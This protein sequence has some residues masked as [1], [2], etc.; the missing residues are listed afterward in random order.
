MNSSSLSRI[1]VFEDELP[2]ALHNSSTLRIRLA[3]FRRNQATTGELLRRVGGEKHRRSLHD[4]RREQMRL[5][6][7]WRLSRNH[8]GI[9]RTTRQ[10]Q[11]DTNPRLDQLLCPDG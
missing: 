9:S 11:I 1:W 4:L 8:P 7:H 10:Q 6:I 3:P 5:D 2:N